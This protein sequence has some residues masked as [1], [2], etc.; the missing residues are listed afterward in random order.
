VLQR[1]NRLEKIA[2]AVFLVGAV[3]FVAMLLLQKVGLV[4]ADANPIGL[5]LLLMVTVPLAV[6]LGIV[7]QF[8]R[9]T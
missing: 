4:A 7:A 6:L 1:R 9:R 2:L 3:P 8:T 5:G